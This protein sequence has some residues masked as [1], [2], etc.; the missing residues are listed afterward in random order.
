MS[1]LGITDLTTA[2]IRLR[3][4]QLRGAPW[5]WVWLE[6]I[7]DAGVFFGERFDRKHLF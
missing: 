4:N 7:E 6:E 2:A 1:Y 5:S 3:R